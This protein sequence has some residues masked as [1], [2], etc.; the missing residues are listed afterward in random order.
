MGSRCST[1]PEY[2]FVVGRGVDAR[3]APQL[4]SFCHLLYLRAI[5]D[6]VFSKI[7][8]D[9]MKQSLLAC[10]RHADTNELLPEDK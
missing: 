1:I 5:Q 8:N 10:E 4:N 9:I 3:T 2:L 6:S 7:F